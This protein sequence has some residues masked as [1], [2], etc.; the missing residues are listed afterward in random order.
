MVPEHCALSPQHHTLLSSAAHCRARCLHK[1][2]S[3]A[4]GVF[5]CGGH[6][7]LCSTAPTARVGVHPPPGHHGT[8]LRR[9]A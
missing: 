6:Q 3:P 8:R 5:H 9:A 7:L 1:L 2:R 4:K